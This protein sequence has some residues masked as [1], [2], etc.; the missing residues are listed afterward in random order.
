MGSVDLI[1]RPVLEFKPE[2]LALVPPDRGSDRDFRAAVFRQRHCQFI[3]GGQGKVADHSRSDAGKVSD[4][5]GS[6][7]L[8]PGQLTM[9]GD[10]HVL[11]RNPPLFVEVC[12]EGFHDPPRCY[13]GSD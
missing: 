4:P 6:G 11:A 9:K 7:L 2:Q 10:N 1:P 8:P 3:A 5:S 13:G 12:K